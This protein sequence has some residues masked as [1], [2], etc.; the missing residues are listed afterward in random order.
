[1]KPQILI[2]SEILRRYVLGSD[3][4]REVLDKVYDGILRELRDKLFNHIMVAEL[5]KL[6]ES[7]QDHPSAVRYYPVIYKEKNYTVKITVE[8]DKPKTHGK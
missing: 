7:R 8:E 1:M 6:M 4:D 3:Q 2:D 5:K